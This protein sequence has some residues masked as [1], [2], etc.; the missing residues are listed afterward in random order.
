MATRRKILRALDERN[1]GRQKA[2]AP[3]WDGDPEDKLVDLAGKFRKENKHDE[4]INC[5]RK[6][7]EGS[8]EKS[9]VV[10]HAG[11]RRAIVE[12]LCAK[13]EY[14][15]ALKMVEEMKFYL[16]TELDSIDKELEEVRM[17][18]AMINLQIGSYDEAESECREVLEKLEGNDK[19][20]KMHEILITLGSV[21][22]H[23]GDL[24]SARRYYEDCLNHL[25]QTERS[26]ELAKVINLLAQLHFVESEWQK[27]LELLSRAL[28]ISEPLKEDGL[29]ASIVG[30]MG[31]VYLML[32]D[33]AK[34]EEYIR[35]GLELWNSLGD[36]L[37]IVRKYISLGNLFMMQRKWDEAEE[38][39]AM[40]REVSREKGYM[41]ELCLSLEFS[42]ELA[43]DRGDFAAAS[44]FYDESLSLARDIASEGDLIGELERRSAELLVKTG[45]LDKA[46]ETC[47]KSLSL[48]L[49]LRDRYEEAVAYRVFGQIFD[50][51]GDTDRARSYYCQGIDGLVSINERYE[52][53]KTLL[54]TAVFLTKNS[55]SPGDLMQADRHFRE[56]AAIFNGLG[57]EYYV[58]KTKKEWDKLKEK[59]P[60][61]EFSEP[62]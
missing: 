38:Y 48:S 5:Y 39:Y 14:S 55:S 29:T 26:Y 25:D 61:P 22:L 58:E 43:F 37:A 45:D 54:D 60:D 47:E 10:E 52:R 1:A 17:I 19:R 33:W 28:R 40:A 35:R 56:A 3:S 34:A 8:S 36:L 2:R 49:R 30:N 6:V 20:R 9:G 15:Q 31:T 11:L 44:A 50:A 62:L 42:G 23:Q 59:Q 21:S 27:S 4:A 13:G 16:A 53:A 51:M 57:V 41:R 18:S 7:L 12:C 46:L 24:E 32:G